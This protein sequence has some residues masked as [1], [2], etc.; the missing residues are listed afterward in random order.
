[1]HRS[2]SARHG[3]GL[4]VSNR[5]AWAKLLRIGSMPIALR[6]SLTFSFFSRIKL[7]SRTINLFGEREI[8]DRLSWHRFD[9]YGTMKITLTMVRMKVTRDDFDATEDIGMMTWGVNDHDLIYK[10]ENP[11]GVACR[12]SL[13]A[14][15]HIQLFHSFDTQSEVNRRIFSH[16][17]VAE[18]QC[19]LILWNW[20]L[21]TD[22]PWLLNRNENNK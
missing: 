21:A 12:S 5:I 16:R 15:V 9:H 13:D 8:D 1:M 17:K 11:R 20:T 19:V 22:L 4:S 10:R 2:Y 7:V 3:T 14:E 18:N 6:I